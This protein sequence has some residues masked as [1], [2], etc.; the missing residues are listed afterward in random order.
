MDL[1]HKVGRNDMVDP[2]S[3]GIAISATKVLLDKAVEIKDIAGGLD[4]LF[5]AVNEKPKPKKKPVA[6]TRT[7]QLLRLKSGET[8]EEAY[9][10]DSDSISAVA[11]DVLEKQKHDAAIASLAREINNKFPQPQ[12]DPTTWDLILAEQAKRVAAKVELKKKAK[13]KARIKQEEDDKYWDHVIA[14]LRNIGILL[15]AAAFC[16]GAGYIIV[17]NKCDTAVC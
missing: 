11:N 1:L 10:E 15:L 13:E 5:H 17:L 7:Q 4:K 16:V 12:G 6:K 8:Q 2:I 14:V 9:A 3:I